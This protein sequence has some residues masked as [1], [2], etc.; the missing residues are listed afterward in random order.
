MA[1]RDSC[2][3]APNG[4]GQGL[5]DVLDVHVTDPLDE[6]LEEGNRVLARDERVARVHVHAEIGAVAEGQHLGHHLGLGGEVAVRLDVDGNLMRLGDLDDLRVAALHHLHCFA[7]A[8]ALRRL[9]SVCRV[10][11][12]TSDQVS[13]LDRLHHVGHAA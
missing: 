6:L 11:T 10:H 9:H 5:R 13:P 1:D 8:H 12:G 7:V 4:R 2:L 3:V